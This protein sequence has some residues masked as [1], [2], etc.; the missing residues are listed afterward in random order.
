[1][2]IE[3]HQLR[4]FVAAAESGSLSGAARRCHVA[5]PSL[6]QQVKKLEERL[7]VPLFDRQGRGV[8]LTAAGRALL[9]RA[10]RILAEVRS[11]ESGLRDEAAEGAGAFSLGAIPT[12]APY[13]LPPVLRRL[14]VRFPRAEVVVREDLTERLV[15][16]VADNELDCAVMSTPVDHPLLEVE[17]VGEE[18]LL[19]VVPASADL[20]PGADVS[21]ASLRDE[22]AVVLLEMHCLGKQIQAFCSRTGVAKRVV[23]RTAQIATLLELVALGFGVSIVP[24]MAAVADRSGRR[25]YHRVKRQPPRRAIALVRR[26]DR[27]P[28]AVV[29]WLAETLRQDLAA[30]RHALPR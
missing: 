29:S 12:M 3:I 15:D 9:P 6:S 4:Y 17:V 13:L 22:P 2:A 27:T 11:V 8:A 1:M 26:R 7:G 23:C 5:Q 14:A 21:I 28:S 24:E 20:P 10:K 25:R 16:A 19:V 18:E 30:G